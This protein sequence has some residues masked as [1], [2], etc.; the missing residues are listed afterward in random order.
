MD[1][2][3]RLRNILDSKH[4]SSYKVAKETQISKATMVNYLDGR[5]NPTRVNI[6][7]ISDFLG[8]NEEWLLNGEGEMLKEDRKEQEPYLITKSGTKY[9][10]LP[11][12]K[13][14]MVVPFVPIKAFAG[15]VDNCCDAIYVESLEER[16][17][18]VNEIHHG[19]Y[20][21]F[22]ISGDSMTYNGRGALYHGDIV[23]VRDLGK[24]HWK[25]GLNI[26]KYPVWVIVLKNTV[27]CKQITK[28]DS[29]NGTITC[30]SLN[31]SPEYSDFE[32][33]LDE[34][35]QLMNVIKVD[36]EYSL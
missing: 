23:L 22:E 2:K 30:H 9:Y 13:F 11:N 33:K 17:F 36:S 27:V 26:N 8:V 1:F 4:I 12:G 35:L 15:Y 10:E 5:T 32:I 25:D 14:K 18:V 34:V 29:E 16:D 3:D 21:S 31:P 24:Q 6:K 20:Y 7:L 28:Q 19:K